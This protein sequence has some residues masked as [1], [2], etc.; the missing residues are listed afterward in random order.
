MKSIGAKGLSKERISEICTILT[1]WNGKLTWDLLVKK[2][3]SEMN[4]KVSRQTLNAYFS[5]KKEFQIKKDD[6]R[7][8]IDSES[9]PANLKISEKDLLKKIEDQQKI[10]KSL[11]QKI[12][13]Q[14]NQLKS[15]VYN[16][17]NI[18]GIDLSKLNIKKHR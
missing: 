8:G 7:K 11:E 10:I 1:T 14:T 18:P 9:Y 3:A 5:I 12:N 16:I 15:F 17:R 2:I 13:E 6:L 4:L